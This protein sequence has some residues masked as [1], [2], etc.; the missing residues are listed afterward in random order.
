MWWLLGLVVVEYFKI[1]AQKEKM[2]Q[3]QTPMRSTKRT[4]RFWSSL[5]INRDDDSDTNIG[6]SKHKA[7][8]NNKSKT[9]MNKTTAT[10]A[11]ETP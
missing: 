2:G 11:V 7:E 6:S 8:R 10:T 1:F 9:S 3:H 5:I 4:A